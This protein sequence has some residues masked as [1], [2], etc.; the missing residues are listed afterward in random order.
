[1]KSLYSGKNSI[2]RR[3]LMKQKRSEERNKMEEQINQRILADPCAHSCPSKARFHQFTRGPNGERNST[4]VHHS[5]EGAL[6]F[7]HQSLFPPAVPLIAPPPLPDFSGHLE[8]RSD[9]PNHR[10]R[11]RSFDVAMQPGCHAPR[12]R[13]AQSPSVSPVFNVNQSTKPSQRAHLSHAHCSVPFPVCGSTFQRRLRRRVL[14]SQEDSD[15]ALQTTHESSPVSG[16]EH[17]HVSLGLT[18]FIERSAL[19]S[20]SCH[21]PQHRI[22]PTAIPVFYRVGHNV[23]SKT[24]TAWVSGRSH[25]GTPIER[26]TRRHIA[27]VPSVRQKLNQAES[28][29]RCPIEESE[30]SSNSTT[31]EQCSPL[32]RPDQHPKPTV[33]K[34]FADYETRHR[35]E[36]V[37]SPVVSS[38]HPNRPI[39]PSMQEV[40]KFIHSG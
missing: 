14:V 27:S 26:S 23:R 6:S 36:R 10:I 9:N 12:P 8:P 39:L 4:S 34:R 31:E 37:A 35:V 24:G 18:P 7:A 13:F 5:S 28:L 11:K 16:D 22:S 17:L 33:D 3:Q 38:A 1:M 32:F 19:V 20:H 2:S 29:Q 25:K 21:C 30:P 40:M 15:S